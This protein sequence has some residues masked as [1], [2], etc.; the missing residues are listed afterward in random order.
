[1]QIIT[2]GREHLVWKRSVVTVGTF[3]G[4]HLGHQRLLAELVK[5]S[6][7]CRCQPVAVTFTNHPLDVVDP[8]ATPRQLTSMSERLAL[9]EA[10]GVETCLLL[11][12]DDKLSK[13]DAFGFI[14]YLR[15]FF[16]V[17]AVV[18]GFNNRFGARGGR[19]LHEAVDEFDLAWYVA[20]E[21][22]V[23]GITVS[24]SQIRTLLSQQNIE[25]ANAMLGRY[26]S[27]HGLVGEGKH[28][29]RTIGFPT[30]NILVDDS[31]TLIPGNGV[32]FG[33]ASV[34]GTPGELYR[35]MANIGYNPTV[36]DGERLGVEVHLIGLPEETELYG[37][38]LTFSF[39]RFHRNEQ[40]FNGIE[41]LKRQLMQDREAIMM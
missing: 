22:K 34:D 15:R 3:D 19:T 38:S 2:V 29:G 10:H 40:R 31:M 27:I 25:E 36:S 23:N 8:G 4:V 7:A 12:F 24:S 37:R 13:L 9:L 11:E 33:Y 32:Y 1:M 5:A 6:R 21:V 17:Q 41:E 14:E 16:N 26:Y 20:P 18:S 35:A 39:E 30:A 28:L